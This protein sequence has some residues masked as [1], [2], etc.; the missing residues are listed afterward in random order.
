M[1]E[2]GP[3][4]EV[5][6]RAK[7][8]FFQLSPG[9]KPHLLMAS[10]MF[11]PR[12]SLEQF[13]QMMTVEAR[14]ATAKEQPDILIREKETG[15]DLPESVEDFQGIVITGSPFV[16]YPRETEE[17]GEKELFIAKWKYDLIKFIRAA[18]EH[19]I[20]IL[21]ICFGAQIL[22]EALGGKV[23]KMKTEKGEEVW[24]TAWSVIKR[25]PGSSDDPIMRGLPSEFVAPQNHT[26]IVARLPEGAVLLAENKYGVQGFRVEKKGKSVAWGFQFHPE[27]SA[28]VVEKALGSDKKR[29]EM[30][31]VGLDP[32]KIA[33]LGKGYGGEVTRIFPNF[34][35][36]IWSGAQ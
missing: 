31:E 19:D 2:V 3:K 16:A 6:P 4:I 15:L 17:R 28:V 12:E 27:R 29:A 26:D 34:L 11:G 33:E 24:E 14:A 25:A 35:K 8:L 32:E 13:R 21:G 5:E 30:R 20:P 36:H 7:I 22:A 23:V 1:A 18:V 10:H 9:A